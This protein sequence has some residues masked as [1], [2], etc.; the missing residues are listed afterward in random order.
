V[1]KNN[2]NTC[3]NNSFI[4]NLRF[5]FLNQPKIKTLFEYKSPEQRNLFSQQ[6]LA[7][8]GVPVNDYSILNI[9]KIG[10]DVPASNVFEELLSWDGNSNFWPNR[11]AR[12]KRIDGSLESILIYIF[13]IE[14]I[15]LRWPVRKSLRLKPLFNMTSLK[16]Q[17]TPTPDSTNNAR[18]LLYECSGGYP[19]GIFSLYV[20]ESVREQNETGTTQ[21]FSIVAFN[22]YGKKNWFYSDIINPVWEKIHNKVTNNVLN[23][24]KVEFEKKYINETLIL[25]ENG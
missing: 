21:L 11:I 12:V 6:I 5:Y 25:E 15:K 14:K 17:Y 7:N 10:I 3:E 1:Q 19:I 9:H 24:M 22:F 8:L 20:R 23:R 18:Y 13:G 16:F 4:C 2:P